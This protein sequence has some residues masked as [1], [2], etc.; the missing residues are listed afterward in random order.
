VKIVVSNLLEKFSTN[1]LVLKE[2]YKIL[3]ASQYVD[4]D[5]VTKIKVRYTELKDTSPTALLT[6]TRFHQLKDGEAPM[7]LEKFVKYTERANGF[8]GDSDDLTALK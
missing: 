3:K 1:V 4:E 8:S 5:S 2:A 6:L 7:T